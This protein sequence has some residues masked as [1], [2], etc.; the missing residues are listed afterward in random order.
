[1]TVGAAAGKPVAMR[2]LSRVSA[3]L[4][5]L[6]ALAMPLAPS[7]QTA[8]PSGLRI[9]VPVALKNAKVVFNM[10]HLAFAGDLP[11]GLGYM[12]IMS[13]DFSA[14]LV[15]WSITAIFHGAAGYMM[16]DD[17]AYDRVRKTTSGNPYKSMVAQ[18]Q[19]AGVHFEEC[20]Q[21]ARDNG[22]GNADLL[23]GV[24]VNS[25]ANFR[26]VQLVQDGF[27]QIQP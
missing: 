7:A 12:K 5:V 23:P 2:T 26:I 3:G 20:G 8:T 4:L 6:V 10:D 16:L 18:L 1:L 14:A 15:P 9:D 17:A 25:G 27:V 13:T 11:I 22:W 24:L 19:K 21:T